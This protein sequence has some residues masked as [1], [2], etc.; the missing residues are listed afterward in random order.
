MC[1]P[2]HAMTN[3]KFV[4]YKQI[5]PDGAVSRIFTII[6]FFFFY[7]LLYSRFDFKPSGFGVLNHQTLPTAHRSSDF[8]MPNHWAVKQTIQLKNSEHTCIQ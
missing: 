7:I 3:T 2:K 4:K 8:G 5:N 6:L 1:A